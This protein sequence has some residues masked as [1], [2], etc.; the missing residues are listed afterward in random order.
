MGGITISPP[1]ITPYQPKEVDPLASYARLVQLRNLQQAGQFQQGQQ[2]LQQQQIQANQRKQQEGE[3]IR[4]AFVNN[5]GDIDK[6]I[7]ETTKNPLVS[8]ETLQALELHSADLKTKRMAQSKAELELRAVQ[9][10]NLRGLFRPVYDMAADAPPDQIEARYQQQRALALQSPEAYGIT[11]PAHVPAQFPGKE[12]GQ[13]LMASMTGESKQIEEAK[14]RREAATSDAALPGVR[15]ESQRKQQEA[16]MTPAER[17]LQGNLAFQAASGNPQA[18]NAMQMEQQGKINVAAAEA[19]ARATAGGAGNEASDDELARGMVD[20]SVDITKVASMRSGRREALVSKAMQLDPTFSMA[21]YPQR[22]RVQE[23]FSSGKAADQIASLNT[24]SGHVADASDLV[25]SL[26]NTSSPWL[27][28]PLNKMAVGLGN[29]KI[30]PFQAALTAAKDEYLNFLKAGHAPQQQ[31]LQL[32]EKLVSPNQ[33][34]AQLQA[35]LKQMT[36]TIL[37]RAGSLNSEYA[38]TMHKDYPM[39]SQDAVQALWKLGYGD[40]AAKFAGGGPTA[41]GGS[42]S[43]SPTAIGPNGHRITVVN[44]RWVDA[45]TGAPIQ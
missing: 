26:R 21:T 40:R 17:G 36:N 45:Q 4:Q 25:D 43:P 39:L 33:S 31:E 30:G 42:N 22:L 37:I 35:V 15:A 28:A 1:P 10:D 32:A 14:A 38:R 16:A 34:P 44:G 23:K 2:Q 18:R 27:N 6:T 29:D 11:D 20:G 5:D 8:P 24:F 9:V 7:T 13:F 12:A 3:V 19:R 41:A